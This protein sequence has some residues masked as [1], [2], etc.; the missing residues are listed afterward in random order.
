MVA[1][2]AFL[3]AFLVRF[4]FQDYF[5]PRNP[6]LFFT[7]ATLVVHFFFGL[8]PAVAVALVSLPTGVYFFVPPYWSFETPD[9]EDLIRIMSFIAYTIFYMV[10]IQYLRRAQY[11]S[12]L[13]AEIAE[14][15]DGVIAGVGD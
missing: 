15:A 1:L 5:G 6:L 13:L 3:V 10:L 11:Q 9:R 4:A 7:I 12:V 8:A 14:F 2:L